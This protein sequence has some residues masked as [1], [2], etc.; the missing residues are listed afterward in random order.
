MAISLKCKLCATESF[1]SII[2]SLI[3]S[4]IFRHLFTE[5]G[6]TAYMMLRF[7]CHSLAV[8]SSCSLC[9]AYHLQ[10]NLISFVQF[11]WGCF[12]G[13]SGGQSSFI[14]YDTTGISFRDTLFTNQRY[15]CHRFSCALHGHFCVTVWSITRTIFVITRELTTPRVILV[16]IAC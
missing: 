10:S 5:N 7:L 11:R 1:I 9:R 2:F 16:V 3:E 4:L 14:T 13:H 15:F 8:Y 6:H 12:R